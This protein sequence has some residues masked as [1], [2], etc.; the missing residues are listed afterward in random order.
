M[1]T[2]VELTVA[3]SIDEDRVGLAVCPAF[4]V[5]A[6]MFSCTHVYPSFCHLTFALTGAQR[7]LRGRVQRGVRLR[8]SYTSH[9]YG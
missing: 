2:T 5:N 9:R 1:P 8:E 6:K 4:R 3:V 7:R